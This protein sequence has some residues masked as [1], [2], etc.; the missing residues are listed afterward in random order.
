MKSTGVSLRAK[1][2]FFLL[3]VCFLAGCSSTKAI[4]KNYDN[5]AS[6]GHGVNAQAAKIMAQRILIGTQEKESYR[7]SY[8]DIKNGPMVSKYPD[9]WFVVFGHNWLEPMTG[10]PLVENY[11]QLLETQYLVV[12]DKNTGKMPFFGEWYPKRENDFDWVFDR[13][14]YNRK[15][16]LVLPPGKQSKA[17]F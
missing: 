12:I 14:A 7:I 1:G 4:Y 16:P 6:P 17:L 5:L 3:A 10:S 8:P 15:D 9:Y 11:K 2:L 13:H